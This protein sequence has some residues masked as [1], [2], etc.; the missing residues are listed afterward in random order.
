MKRGRKPPREKRAPRRPLRRRRV[1]GPKEEYQQAVDEAEVLAE[2][3][4]RVL[5]P[6]VRLIQKGLDSIKTGADYLAASFEDYGG[7]SS[8]WELFMEPVVLERLRHI[9][10]TAGTLARHA[11]SIDEDYAPM[12]NRLVNAEERIDEKWEEW[13]HPEPRPQDRLDVLERG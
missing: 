4:E 1:A 12:Y 11:Q 10:T 9:V 3:L 5:A 8:G 2:K 6:E 7:D 13:K